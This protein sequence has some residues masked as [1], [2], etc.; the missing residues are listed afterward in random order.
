[1][2]TLLAIAGFEA[3]ARLARLSTWVYFAT[4]LALSLL[5]TAAAG[6]AFRNANI[7]FGSGKVWI[8]SPYAV[9][10][11]L[12]V[13]GM[14]GAT[15]IAAL[16]G[17]A[18]QQ[19]FEY[20]TEPFFF[21]AP[22]RKWQYLGGRYAGAL[23]VLLIVFASIALGSF[24]GT[25]WPGLDPDRL[26]PPRVGVY[27]V[28]YLTV[29]LPNLV[30]LGGLFFTL[31]ALA[32]R[33][34][35][36][37]IGSVLC[38]VGYL[39][40]TGLLRDLD[41]KTLAALSDPFGVIATARLTEY[42]TIAER[43]SRVVPLEGVLL[44]NR[45]LW[46]GVGVLLLAF[47][48]AR[49]R[50]AHAADG[51]RRTRQA[52]G[53]AALEPAAPPR[54][55]PVA[56]QRVLGLEL[57]PRLAWLYFRETVKNIHFGV[58]ALAGVLFL[59]ANS[60]TLGSLFG[61]TTWPV[62]YQMLELLSGSFAIFML[63]ILTF[64]AGELVWRERDNRFDQIHD[65]LPIPTW[66]PFAAKLA[67]LML[68]PVLL[69]ALLMLCG[70]AIQTFKGYHHYEIGLYLR[71]LFGID[72]VSYWLLCV[73]AIAVHSIV[74]QKYVGHFVMIVYFLLLA[75]ASRWASSTTCTSTARRS[76]TRTRT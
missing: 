32:R 48:Y 36:V 12:A 60:T 59:I 35:P 41:N 50:F 68:V 39:V 15:V 74:N 67:A 26:G 56:P 46:V 6:G 24:L 52:Q 43:N 65:A 29:L 9:A 20:R 34:L 2:G 70:I 53:D 66:L 5:W 4:F 31:G 1:M 30:W 18:I 23:A 57:L 64:Y 7:V 13:L 58:I 45:L 51:G 25:L 72:L 19:D 73:L 55:R 10:Q 38:I 33:M 40:G 71:D 63:V 47:C 21:T 61:T 14:A 8:N 44:W 27:L 42:W 62:T 16:F 76:R 3:R 54:A 75:F 69:Q 17:R 22:I 49:F 11:T 37:Y 28:P